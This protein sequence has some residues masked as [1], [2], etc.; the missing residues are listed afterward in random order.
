[1]ASPKSS[2]YA[3]WFRD[4][5]NGTLDI[6]YGEG[7]ASD[8]VEIAQVDTSGLTV[9]TGDLGVAAGTLD[10]QDGGTIGQGSGSGKATAVTLSTHSGQITLNNASLAA[11]A[12]VT[13]AVTNTTVAATDVV[14]AI[15]GSAGTAGAYLVQ[16]NTMAAGSFKVTVAN[17]STGSLG[18][19]IV[20]N[21]VVIKGASS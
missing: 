12:E 19:A 14:I 4:K 18:E 1:M 8:P 10:V 6:Y 7:G 11:A 9:I 15:H 5:E 16:A 20:V 13:F 17:L 2:S 21:F 3:G